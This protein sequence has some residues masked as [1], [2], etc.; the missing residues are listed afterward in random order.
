MAIKTTPKTRVELERTR[1]LLRVYVEASGI[2]P[3]TLAR[4]LGLETTDLLAMLSEP[5]RGFPLFQLFQVLEALGV[6]SRAFFGRLYGWLPR[7]DLEVEDND[8]TG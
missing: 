5:G 4:G 3:E 8:N 6:P 7:T 2:R 1:E